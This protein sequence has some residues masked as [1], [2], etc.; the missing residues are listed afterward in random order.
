[1]RGE[2]DGPASLDVPCSTALAATWDPDLVERIGH[3]LGRETKAKGCYL[4]T[5]ASQSDV[6]PKFVPVD[7]FRWDECK[8]NANGAQHADDGR[9]HSFTSTLI[10]FAPVIA[11]PPASTSIS[12]ILE[13]YVGVELRAR[14]MASEGGGDGKSSPAIWNAVSGRHTRT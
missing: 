9:S 12:A 8:V 6:T 2:G 14:I 7:V 1:M 11:G 5:V 4:V 13:L 10:D 3:V